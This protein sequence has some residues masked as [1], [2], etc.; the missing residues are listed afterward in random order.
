MGRHVQDDTDT[1]FAFSTYTFVLL[2]K[3]RHFPKYQL[4]PSFLFVFSPLVCLLGIHANS[5][6]AKGAKIRTFFLRLIMQD[7]CMFE[8]ELA[9]LHGSGSDF[10][11]HVKIRTEK[12]NVSPLIT[13]SANVEPWLEVR[14]IC[15][16]HSSFFWC[17]K[18]KKSKAPVDAT[19]PTAVY[20]TRSIREKTH[21]QRHTTSCR[22]C[23]SW[24]SR[25]L[26]MEIKAQ[27]PHWT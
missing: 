4:V 27:T 20:G 17:K 13:C 14:S 1:L 3:L 6:A 9:D 5:Q 16:E 18:K 8:E 25:N 7:L 12:A 21:L 23:T 10:A 2:T 24:T 15:K 11:P 22:T 26:L 19:N